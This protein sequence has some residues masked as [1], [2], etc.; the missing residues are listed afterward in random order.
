MSK[1]INCI[2]YNRKPTEPEV[3]KAMKG[4]E[5][6]GILTNIE[7]DNSTRKPVL[8]WETSP[9]NSCE[10]VFRSDFGIYYIYLIQKGR[11][12]GKYKAMVDTTYISTASGADDI[13]I[14]PTADKAKVAC[15]D[16]LEV[17]LE[18]LAKTYMK[19]K[20]NR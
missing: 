16:H 7:E 20:G 1:K 14:Y 2:D 11:G 10:G 8:E 6:A 12:K 3:T 13:G 15:E 9:Y 18:P 5:E 4:M 17:L 19:L